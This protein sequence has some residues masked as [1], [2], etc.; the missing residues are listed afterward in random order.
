MTFTPE[1]G[2]RNES[3]LAEKQKASEA[4][5][6]SQNTQIVKNHDQLVNSLNNG[7]SV[8]LRNANFRDFKTLLDAGREIIRTTIDNKEPFYITNISY[9]HLSGY[10]GYTDIQSV[11]L[12]IE[13]RLQKKE[14]T[15]SILYLNDKFGERNL[16][17]SHYVVP[18]NGL[19]GLW[20]SQLKTSISIEEIVN[21]EMKTKGG[22]GV[23]LPQMKSEIRGFKIYQGNLE[24][25]GNK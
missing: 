15:K 8:I 16:Q 5:V 24:I 7:E 2:H 6:L 13:A 19:K 25:K 14:E 4:L 12:V 20:R 3:Q 22:F 10:G 21:G 1:F 11:G 18:M 17:T 23:Y 9:Q